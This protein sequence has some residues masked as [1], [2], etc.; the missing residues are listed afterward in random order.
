MCAKFFTAN[1]NI[2]DAF[3][4]S[5]KIRMSCGKTSY[6]LPFIDV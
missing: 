2:R 6:Y 1:A 5:H 4:S 3:G